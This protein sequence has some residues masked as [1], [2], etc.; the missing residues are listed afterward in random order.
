MKKRLIGYAGWV[1]T[2]VCLY[3]F[4]NNTGTR[5]ILVCSLAV[6]LL[7]TMRSAFFIPEKKKRGKARANFE[8]RHCSVAEAEEAG[9]VRPYIPGDPVGRIHWKLSAKKDELLVRGTEEA[10]WA[11]RETQPCAAKPERPEGSVLRR[12]LPGLTAVTL[13]CSVLLFALPEGRKGAQALCNRLFTASEAVNRYAYERFSV[14]EG[15]P[16]ALAVALIIMTLTGLAVT[17]FLLRSRVLTLGIAAGAALF[18]VYFGLAFPG[19]VNI[20]LY[21]TLGYLLLPRRPSGRVMGVY[22]A[23]ILAAGMLTAALIP[24]VDAATEAASEHVR[25]CLSRMTQTAAEEVHELAEGETET[26]HV[27]TRTPEAGEGETGPGREF[28]AVTTE[29]EKISMPRWVNW[30]KIVLLLLAAVMLVVLPFIPIAIL[31]ARRRKARESRKIFESENVG[32]AICAIYQQV[33]SWLDATRRGEGNR[34]YRDW[35]EGLAEK[36]P[37][38]YT[39]LFRECTAYFEEA[40]YSRHGLTEEKREQTLKLLKDTETILWQKADRKERFWLKYWM[41]LCE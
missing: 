34:L 12:V 29:E 7:P 6:P 11:K 40:A 32:E 2:A 23:L 4:E 37:E 19:W 15:Q 21:G 31:N 8:S 28:R 33:I 39:A 25:D 9:D 3:F 35:A 14:P 38:A 26:R 1:L 41:C 30:L 13:A 10:R 17:A 22:G 27:H 5:I 24:G 20:L 16:A 18:Q 36:M